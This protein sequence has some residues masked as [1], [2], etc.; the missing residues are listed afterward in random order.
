[1]RAVG[2]RPSYRVQPSLL[3][4][5]VLWLT[6]ACTGG[7]NGISA[8]IMQQYDASPTTPIDLSRVGPPSWERVCILGPYTNNE[9][10][11]LL[12]GFKWDAE[13]KTPIAGDDT[14]NVLVFI[15]NQ[16][17]IAYAEHPRGKG[18]FSVVEPRCLDR[19]HAVLMRKK[20]G[21]GWV[22]LV[23]PEQHKI[24]E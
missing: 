2:T 1:M 13:A 15:R 9:R 21:D 4:G 16:E 7:D 3:L 10:A 20:R 23:T 11:E 6:T 24:N 17:V 14:I 18:D 8:Q 5:A 12:L 22:H 19:E